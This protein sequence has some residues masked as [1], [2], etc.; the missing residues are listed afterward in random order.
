[1]TPVP[2]K[3][4]LLDTNVPS[5][6]TRP[7]PNPKV[8]AWVESQNSD[9]FHLS[10]ITV[11]E[12]RKGVSLLS[13][14]KR[15]DRLD[16]WLEIN[17]LPLFATRILSV[18]QHIADRWGVLSAARQLKG[19]PLSM[20]DGLIAATALEYDLILVTRNAKDFAHLGLTILDPWET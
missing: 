2:P 10:A 8:K 12:L 5:E 15:R 13:P 1:M 11:G 19:Q 20:A 17:L 14:G 16:H 3:G 18:T 9:S 4:F 7:A 6:L